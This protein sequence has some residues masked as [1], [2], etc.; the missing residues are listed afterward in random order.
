MK[1]TTT[2]ILTAGIFLS[3][4]MGAAMAHGLGPGGRDGAYFQRPAAPNVLYL[5]S[6]LVRSGSSDAG[7]CGAHVVPFR[8]N[9]GTLANPG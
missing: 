7:R 8:G 1:T 3:L 9:Y 2:L 5:A 6:G 4:G